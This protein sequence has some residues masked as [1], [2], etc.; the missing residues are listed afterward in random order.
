MINTRERRETTAS[1]Q[2]VIDHINGLLGKRLVALE[3]YSVARFTTTLFEDVAWYDM[4]DTE[5][6]FLDA[7]RED[8]SIDHTELF[9]LVESIKNVTKKLLGV[10]TR[11]DELDRINETGIQ[12]LRFAT[13]EGNAIHSSDVLPTI[14]STKEYI[15]GVL[16]ETLTPEGTERDMGLAAI[17]ELA[18]DEF[19]HVLANEDNSEVELPFTEEESV[20]FNNY[21]ESRDVWSKREFSNALTASFIPR[22]TQV[23][24]E[25]V[26]PLVAML[27]NAIEEKIMGY[28]VL[29]HVLSDAYLDTFSLMGNQMSVSSLTDMLRASNLNEITQKSERRDLVELSKRNAS[30]MRTMLLY[31]VSTKNSGEGNSIL[32]FSTL[33]AEV[34]LNIASFSDKNELAGYEFLILAQAYAEYLDIIYKKHVM[35]IR[36]HTTVL[37]NSLLKKKIAIAQTNLDFYV[38]RMLPREKV[39]S[40]RKEYVNFRGNMTRIRTWIENNEKIISFAKE[41]LLV[42]GGVKHL[43]DFRMFLKERQGFLKT[44]GDEDGLGVGSRLGREAKIILHAFPPTGME[45]RLHTILN[46]ATDL[47]IAALEEMEMT[48]AVVIE[49]LFGSSDKPKQSRKGKEKEEEMPHDHSSK[50]SRIGRARIERKRTL[51][52]DKP[53]LSRAVE[54]KHEK[55]LLLF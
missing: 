37:A 32:P 52:V 1:K 41:M 16:H 43:I 22:I 48:N 53:V 13:T 31:A 54:K 3:K 42:R 2:Y 20:A 26:G 33:P 46:R 36:Y 30:R 50:R 11:E 45:F 12:N 25:T 34:A 24:T 18:H 4:F 38:E 6:E 39:K 7:L 35:Q 15:L 21:T 49:S 17:T 47:Q 40:K 44:A 9:Y 23:I 55:S 51:R 8:S 5:G 10:E 19:S 29:F 28:I 27:E 14:T